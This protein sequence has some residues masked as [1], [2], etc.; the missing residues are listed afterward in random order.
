[1]LWFLVGLIVDADIVM[2]L[3]FFLLLPLHRTFNI[4]T[5][6]DF[7]FDGNQSKIFFLYFTEE[8]TAKHIDI[9]NLPDQPDVVEI[10]DYFLLDLPHSD[11][12]VAD[13]AAGG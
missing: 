13:V 10:I 11:D 6:I 8:R 3:Q 7:L 9:V 2:I 4:L 1:M 5:L 12:I